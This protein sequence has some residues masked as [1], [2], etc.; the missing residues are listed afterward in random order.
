MGFG[1]GRIRGYRDTDTTHL[2]PMFGMDKKYGDRL[3]PPGTSSRPASSAIEIHENG[4]TQD[5]VYW[6]NINGSPTQIYCDMTNDGGGWM[7]YSS[8]ASDN[9]YDAS[10]YPALNG[11]RIGVSS[12]GLGNYGYSL[13]YTTSWADG[14]SS[15]NYGRY[16][17]SSGLLAH[18]Y[19]GSPNGQLTMTSWNGPQNVSELRIQTAS[20]RSTGSASGNSRIETNGVDRPLVSDGQQFQEIVV[21][22]NP[23]GASPI[24]RQ[25]ELS[26]AGL[27]W[28]FCR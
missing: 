16:S 7:L 4:P 11:N 21:P 18:Y 22:F 12:N 10:N 28:I 27:G 8:F 26:I 6:I 19:S 5:G 9:F 20:A 1:N 25:I 24:F 13:N 14:Y 17:R 15:S 3:F 2:G 23:S